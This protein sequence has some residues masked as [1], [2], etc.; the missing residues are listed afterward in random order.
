MHSTLGVKIDSILILRSQFFDVLRETLYFVQTYVLEHL[1]AAGPEK[2][3]V[4]YTSSYS[5]YLPGY[6]SLMSLKVRDWSGHIFGASASPGSLTTKMA[7]SPSST[8]HGRQHD[9]KYVIFPLILHAAFVVDERGFM[10]EPARSFLFLFLFVV[11]FVVQP[12]A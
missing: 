5:K 2:K 6:L 8:V 7:M 12:A 9:T 4:I 10:H 3:E 1:G 11:S